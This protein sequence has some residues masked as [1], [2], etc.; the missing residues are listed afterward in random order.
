MILSLCSPKD[1]M[2]WGQIPSCWSDPDLIRCPKSRNPISGLSRSATFE[3]VSVMSA[4]PPNS[5]SNRFDDDR[6]VW[7][8]ETKRRPELARVIEKEGAKNVHL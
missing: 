8:D 2:R 1:A 7:L 5:R 6:E 4:L 3:H